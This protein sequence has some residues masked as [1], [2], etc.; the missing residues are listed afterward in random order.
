MSTPRSRSCCPGTRGENEYVDDTLIVG[1]C[2]PGGLQA[3]SLADPR[4]PVPVWHLPAGGC[5]E[6]TPAV[7]GG[8]IVVGARD[9][10][11]YGFGD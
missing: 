4:R 7:Y 9:G 11:L 1:K 6:S 3:Y 5:I 2:I 8:L 10:Y